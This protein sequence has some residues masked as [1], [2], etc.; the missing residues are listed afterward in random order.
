LAHLPKTN[1][2][3]HRPAMGQ[4][5]ADTATRVGVAER[6]PEPAVQ[7]RIEVDLARIGHDDERLRD[8]ELAI[9]STA[10]HHNANTL[11]LRRTVPQLGAIR[12]LV[13]LD[14]IHAVP[15]FPRGQDVVASGR[16]L[17]CAQASAGKR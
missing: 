5:I 17:T 3:Y 2:Q 13:R 16:L 7:K 8:V 6:C 11:S 12:S 9:G 10:K 15:R 4:K 14:A 1:S